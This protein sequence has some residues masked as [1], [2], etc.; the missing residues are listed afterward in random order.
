M[1]AS[2]YHDLA[3]ALQARTTGLLLRVLRPADFS[4]RCT[5]AVLLSCLVVAAAH[6]LSLAAVAAVRRAWPTSGSRRRP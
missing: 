1:R 5:A 6:R 3:H 2:Q 4:R